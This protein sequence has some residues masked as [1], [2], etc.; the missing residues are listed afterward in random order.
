[1]NDLLH[2]Q[3]Y[4]D[5]GNAAL[6]NAVKKLAKVK[7]RKQLVKAIQK[8]QKQLEAKGFGE[9]YDT[10]PEWEITDWV[11]VNV[12]EPKMWLLIDRWDF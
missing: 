12:C 2:W 8:M 10:E 5:G 6:E 11:N 4:T 3:M 1:M 9:V 7:D